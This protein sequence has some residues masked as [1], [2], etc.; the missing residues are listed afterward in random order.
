MRNLKLVLQYD[1]TPFAGWQRQPQNKHQRTIQ[2]DLEAVLK[3]V[4]QEPIDVHCAGRTDTGVHAREQIAHFKTT[5]SINAEQLRY[6]LNRMLPKEIS[7]MKITD[8]P[9]DFHA[10]HSATARTYRYFIITERIALKHRFAAFYPSKNLDLNAMQQCADVI[11]GEHDFRSFCKVGNKKRTYLC[12][13]RR[14]VWRSI[15]KSE[16]VF[17]ITA[18]RFLHSMV[19]LLVGTMLDVGAGERSVK[20]FREVLLARDV[21]RAGTAAKPCGL[22]FWK[23]HYEKRRKH[24][25]PEQ[26]LETDE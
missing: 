22:F 24:I 13:V 2:G 9:E 7:V 17:E 16:L 3:K 26:E 12:N 6:V 4:L 15:G 14:A 11:V 18:N 20:D 8:A 23:A 25:V 21:R 1:G 19:R 5:S 10:R